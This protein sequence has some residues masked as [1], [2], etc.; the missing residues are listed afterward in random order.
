MVKNNKSFITLKRFLRSEFPALLASDKRS[1]QRN[2]SKKSTDGFETAWFSGKQAALPSNPVTSI[3]EI[4]TA[5][6]ASCTSTSGGSLIS[7][8]C[9]H[10]YSG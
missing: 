5:R 2:G 8:S 7:L 3:N 10:S 6:V 1:T 9:G 4:G